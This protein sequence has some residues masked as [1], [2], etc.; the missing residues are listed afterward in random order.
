MTRKKFILSISVLAVLITALSYAGSE[1]QGETD[2]HIAGPLP[3]SLDNLYPPKAEQPV[4][5]S[6]MLG[7]ST[8]FTAIIVDL[9]ENDAPNAMADYEKFKAEYY[10]V[11]Q[12]VPEWQAMF[13]MAPVEEL[14]AA[15]ETGDQGRV[16]SC[17]RES[18]W[19]A[20]TSVIWC[21]PPQPL[22]DSGGGIAARLRRADW[23]TISYQQWEVKPG[24]A[25]RGPIQADLGPPVSL[26]KTLIYLAPERS[27]ASPIA[28]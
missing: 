14:G 8:P 18:G 23:T 3:V 15:L 7:M 10:E 27:S 9:F 6:R 28:V 2:Q 13:P 24:L 20:A 26:R 5:L 16:G 4:Y 21:T 22:P 11:S 17:P 1:T 19:R 25:P 12:L